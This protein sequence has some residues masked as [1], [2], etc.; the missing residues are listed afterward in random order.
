[1]RKMFKAAASL[2]VGCAM[3]S[4]SAFAALTGTPALS[5]DNSAVNVTVSGVGADKESTI[6]VLKGART[7]MP[8]TIN[9]DDIVY[10]N[11]K[12]AAADGTATY[13]MP[14]GTRVGD[15]TA[16]TVF[17]GATDESAATLL[18]SVTLASEPDRDFITAA[19]TTKATIVEKNLTTVG[20]TYIDPSIAY[21]AGSKKVKIKLNADS[22]KESSSNY[23]I[24]VVDNDGNDV[25]GTE[26]F[27]S[28]EGDFYLALIPANVVT[29]GYKFEVLTGEAINDGAT[30][31]VAFGKISG[32]G[33]INARDQMALK[34]A[35]KG[36]KPF[37]T[38]LLFVTADI[39]ND[40]QINAREQ[41]ALKNKIKNQTGY[42]FDILK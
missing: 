4:T 17:A 25:T 36:T 42:V 8:A 23:L 21:A 15:A 26:I 5:D 32:T 33:K 9:E 12:T 20:K 38:S 39:N 11:Q 3:L 35:I 16:V 40:G 31:I 7:E 34:N 19:D 10:I 18:G 28:V 22:Y 6:L 24:K 14:L 13:S 1:M 2:A 30:K 29:A 37:T 27:Y 41:M